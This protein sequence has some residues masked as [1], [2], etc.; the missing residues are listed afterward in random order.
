MVSSIPN[1]NNLHTDVW[2]QLLLSNT[3]N[4]LAYLFNPYMG[5]LTSTTSSG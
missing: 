3:D 2:F 5:K 1:T 4:F